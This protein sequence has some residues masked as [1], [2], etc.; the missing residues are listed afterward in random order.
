MGTF[1]IPL[2][3]GHPASQ[4]FVEVEALVDTGATHILLPREVLASL[5]TEAIDTVSFQ[6]ADERVVEYE[7]GEARIRLAGRE[8]ALQL[9]SVQWALLPCWEL[10]PWSY[11]TWP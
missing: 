9:P 8:R 4:R 1:T 2:Q 7:V 5:G 10:P 6:L 11:L 3:V